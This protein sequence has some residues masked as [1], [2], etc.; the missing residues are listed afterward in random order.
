MHKNEFFRI[1]KVL[2]AALLGLAAFLPG[3]AQNQPPNI[4]IIYADDLGYGDLG[5]Y[6]GDIPT[7]NID[8]IGQQ[9]IRFTDF[10]V[11]APVC[12]PSRFSLLTGRYPQRSQ[13]DLTRGADA[14]R[15][16]LPRPLGN[17]PGRTPQ[18]PRATPPRC[19]ASGTWAPKIPPTCP[20]ATASTP[21]RASG[22]AASTTSRTSM[23][24][25]AK[26]GSSTAS[27]PTKAATPPNSSPATPPNFWTR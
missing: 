24:V 15:Q 6:G 11:S 13:H 14:L 18:G 17:H 7:P 16:K 4:V 20:R 21:S 1:R 25:W 3:F 19:W 9:G 12:T 5:S 26:T 10:Y 27:P 2:F 8:R 22:R 23:V